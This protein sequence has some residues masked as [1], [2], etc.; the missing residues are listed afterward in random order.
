[1]FDRWHFSRKEAQYKNILKFTWAN[2][3]Y[4]CV[5]ISAIL[6]F[7]ITRLKY[8][9]EAI[10]ESRSLKRKYGFSQR[11]HRVVGLQSGRGPHETPLLGVIVVAVQR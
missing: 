4:Y 6:T 10:F 9:D 8:F 1:V 2:I 11:G 3:L 7:D 5:Y